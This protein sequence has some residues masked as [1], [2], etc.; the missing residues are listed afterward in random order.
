MSVDSAERQLDLNGVRDELRR[1][2][3]DNVCI[4]LAYVCP[5]SFM[6][7]NTVRLSSMDVQTFVPWCNH[8]G[9][10][11]NIWPD[12]ILNGVRSSPRS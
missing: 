10:R 9:A 11:C 3:G 4:T 7:G 5:T 1:H 8:S 6:R 12:S 2:A